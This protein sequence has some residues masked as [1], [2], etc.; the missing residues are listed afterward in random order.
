MIMGGQQYTLNMCNEPNTVQASC[1]EK[2]RC[3]TRRVFLKSM[4]CFQFYN[5]NF[6]V[7]CII[8]LQI[9]CFSTLHA[10]NVSTQNIQKQQK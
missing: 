6:L 10:C 2:T 1:L 5:Q 7:A 4:E 9:E 3:P 8:Y